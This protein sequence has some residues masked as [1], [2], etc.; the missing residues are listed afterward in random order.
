MSELRPFQITTFRELLDRIRGSWIAHGRV[1]GSPGFNAVA[2]H[3]FGQWRMSIPSILLRGP[4]SLLYRMLFRRCRRV[5]GIELP[6][7]VDLGER[8]VFEHQQGIVI[9][10][11]AKIGD[12]SII[13]HGVTLGNRY[14]DA[15]QEAP[16]LG[17]NVNVGT[18]AVILGRVH[19]GDGARIGANAVVLDDVPAGGTATGPKAIVRRDPKL[20]TQAE[21]A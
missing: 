15:P 17:R 12:E 18:G 2:V 4:M 16:I 5:H 1:Y 10:G 21:T 20:L 14:L 3:A 13:R 11:N 19:I 7:T 8:V 6:Y 9:H